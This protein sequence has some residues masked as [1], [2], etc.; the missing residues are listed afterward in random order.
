[1]TRDAKKRER[2]RGFT[3]VE[4]LISIALLIVL[5]VIGGVQFFGYRQQQDLSDAAQELAA[6]FRDAQNRSMSQ[7]SGTRWGVHIENSVSGG[8]FFELF[9]G[10]SYA[11]ANVISHTTFSSPIAFPNLAAGASRNIFFAPITGTASSTAVSVARPSSTLPVYDVMVGSGGIVST[12]LHQ[13][14]AG[15]WHFD[16]GSGT[17]G[18]DASGNGYAANMVNATWQSAPCKAGSCVNLNGSNAYALSPNIVSQFGDGSVTISAWFNAQGPGVVVDELGQSQLNTGWHNSQIEI[19]GNKLYVAVA[20][21]S[22]VRVGTAASNTWHHAVL[23]YNS[24]TQTLDGFLDGVKASTPSVG[25]RTTPWSQGY[26]LYYAMGAGDSN[27]LGPGGSGGGYLNGAVDEVQIYHR[28][29]SDSE[30]A[31]LYNVFR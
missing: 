23:R 25:A 10:T 28:V 5:G 11:P 21:V 15:Y 29:L 6:V 30:V 2:T 12:S 27:N 24:A 19:V 1:M 13:G 3:L 16:D 31:A 17:F 8:Q 26:G 4:L 14:L 7:D 20:N 9:S 18:L 22:S